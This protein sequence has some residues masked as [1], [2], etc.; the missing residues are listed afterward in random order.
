[1]MGRPQASCSSTHTRY[2]PQDDILR[3]A[4]AVRDEPKIP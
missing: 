1:M 3:D 2:R 4:L